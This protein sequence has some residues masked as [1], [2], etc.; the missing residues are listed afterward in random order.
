MLPCF[1]CDV[2]Y[3]LFQFV[4]IYIKFQGLSH[5]ARGLQ[6]MSE[7]IEDCL[8]LQ[9]GCLMGANLAIEVA[10]E[11]FTEATIGNTIV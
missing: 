7:V 11:K 8:G 2:L 6:Q 1:L 3:I 10:D 9:C 5:S 4:N